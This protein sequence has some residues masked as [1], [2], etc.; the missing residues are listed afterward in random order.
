METATPFTVFVL[1]SKL[2]YLATNENKRFIL[3][4]LPQ[5]VSV[6]KE[7]GFLFIFSDV[8]KISDGDQ[9]TFFNNS[10][11]ASFLLDNI[12]EF[13]SERGQKT[14]FGNMDVKSLKEDYARCEDGDGY[15]YDV[16]AD[17]LS[18]LKFIKYEN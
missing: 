4:V 6:A 2:L 8:Q 1:Q 7:R 15:F 10:I 5:M 13:A 18:K 3:S 11:S 14:I 17:K 16:E 12:A 9:N